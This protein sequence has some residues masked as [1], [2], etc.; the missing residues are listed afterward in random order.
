MK[1]YFYTREVTLDQF[2]IAFCECFRYFDALWT[3]EDPED[4]MQ[5]SI[6]FA[7]FREQFITMMKTGKEIKFSQK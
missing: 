7:K 3:A 2:H 1:K 5:F 4:I 6:V